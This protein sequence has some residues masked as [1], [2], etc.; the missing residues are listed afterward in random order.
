MTV[1]RGRCSHG[2]ADQMGT[3]AVALAAFKV[4]VAGGCTALAGLEFVCV[5]GQAHRATG[6]APLKTGGFEYLVQTFALG[7]RFHQA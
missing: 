2:R 1:N 6:F 7:L 3:S 5:H 4:A